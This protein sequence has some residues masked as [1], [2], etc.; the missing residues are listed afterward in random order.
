M[1]TVKYTATRPLEYGGNEYNR[2]DIIMVE[3]GTE[4]EDGMELY[5]RAEVSSTGTPK[6]PKKKVAKA[7]AK[8]ATA[9]K[10]KKKVDEQ[11]EEIDEDAGDDELDEDLDDDEDDE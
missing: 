10:A 8:K 2:G 4:V 11:D 6:A 3:A 5:D 1:K 7:P 9:K